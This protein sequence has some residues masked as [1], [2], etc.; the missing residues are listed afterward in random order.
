VG[1]LHDFA[2]MLLER[3]APGDFQKAT[4]MLDEVPQIST[5]LDMRPLTERVLSIRD[6]LKAS[7]SGAWW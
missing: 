2:D 4:A 7:R 5:D 3:D 1:S 6:I